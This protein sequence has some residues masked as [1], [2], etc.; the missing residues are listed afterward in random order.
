MGMC[1]VCS[2]MLEPLLGRHKQMW[3]RV[4]W[5]FAHSHVFI[6]SGMTGR[7]GSV[8]QSTSTW[9]IHAAWLLHS[10]AASG[11]SVH[12][13]T[14]SSGLPE[15]VGQGAVQKLYCLAWLSR[16]SHT[17]SLPLYSN[18]T[19][20][21]KSAQIQGSETQTP[22]SHEETAK[23]IAKQRM[24]DGLSLCSSRKRHLATLLR[25]LS[26]AHVEKWCWILLFT[27][28]KGMF[29]GKSAGTSMAPGSVLTCHSPRRSLKGHPSLS[30]LGSQAYH[31]I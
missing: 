12:L 4:L 19:N 10:M 27:W 11:Q 16:G 1:C 23:A 13:L 22:T 25:L 5:G 20:N 7:L 3:A 31:A 2:K 6:W 24:L 18:G 30:P 9:P 21:H 17:A 14:R 26:Y 8:D 29:F 15:H 28:T